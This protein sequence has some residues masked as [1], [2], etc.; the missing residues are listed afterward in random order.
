M[1][2]GPQHLE[3]VRH[4]PRLAHGLET[5]S[6]VFTA[7]S[8]VHDPPPTVQAAHSCDACHSPL[9]WLRC[10]MHVCRERWTRHAFQISTRGCTLNGFTECAEAGMLQPS[11]RDSRPC[12]AVD[13]GPVQVVRAVIAG[14]LLKSTEA[15]AQPTAHSNPRQ[16]AAMLA[17]IK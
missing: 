15:L 2:P 3:W 1:R 8:S 5:P 12:Q 7:Q 6:V 14:G 10:R 13:V 16:Q 9:L 4:I 11:F 17:P